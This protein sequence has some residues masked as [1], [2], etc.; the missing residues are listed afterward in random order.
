MARILVAEDDTSTRKLMCAV[1]TRAGFEAIPAA[2][3]LEALHVLDE[4]RVDMLIT[5]VMMPGLN[6]VELVRQLREARYDLPILMVTAKG[7]PVDRREGFI[8]GTDDYMVKPVDAQEMILRVKALLR[9]ARIV[10]DNCVQIGETRLDYETLTVARTGREI[11]LPPKEFRL[12]YKLLSYPGQVFTRLQL[13]DEVWGEDSDSD[14]ATVSVHV[15][16]LRSK[17]S[18]WDDFEIVT[19]R[20]LGYKAVVRSE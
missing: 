17:F 16:R 8:V 11:A 1:L 14:P 2:N 6:G 19:V 12:L 10:A 9:R 20:G 15:N 7:E 4:R 5:D 3:G 13:F 18:D